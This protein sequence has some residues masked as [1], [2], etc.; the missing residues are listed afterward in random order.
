M[1]QW[2]AMV[3][4]IFLCRRRPDVTHERYVELLL[5]THVPIALIHHPAMEKYIVNI[6]EQSPAGEVALDSVGELSFP[7][8]EDFR[9]RLYD[10]AD[11]EKVV[12]RDVARF[13]G[14][15]NAFAVSE[16]VQK[17]EPP[18]A[19]LGTRVAGIKLL[20]PVRRRQNM[21]HDQFVDHWLGRHVPLAL[22]HHPGLVKYVTN[23]VD[24]HL[25]EE[26]ETWDGF[27]ELHFASER[28][29]KERMFDSADGERII[30]E[31]VARFIG[32]SMPY[33]VAE[34]VL[35]V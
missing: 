23:V 28:D 10:S 14:G 20:C 21:T 17:N 9:L 18:P 5:G 29:L 1:G 33:R 25:S 30:L 35:K 22:R 15:A 19:P 8:L 11:G 3:K 27:A 32:H 24:E 12:Q 13:M 26:G 31:D 7:T 16:H 4:L 6:V 2:D 34:Y